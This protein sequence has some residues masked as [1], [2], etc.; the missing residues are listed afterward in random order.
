ML[1]HAAP[2]R[3]G[4]TGEHDA[5]QRD[6]AFSL[7]CTGLGLVAVA[8]GVT[9]WAGMGAWFVPKAIAVFGV[10]S[11]LVWRALP[12]HGPHR[13]FGAA[14]GITLLR[15]ALVA[16]LAAGVGEPA[17]QTPMLA[18]CLV[19]LAT[20]GA[21]LDAADG[22]IARR[23]GQASDFGARFDMETDALL[24]AVLSVLVLALD[25]TGA[26]VL[27]AGAMRYAFVLAA[28]AWPWLAAPLPPSARR[29]TVCVVQSVTLIVC[30]GPVVTPGWAGVIAGAGLAA[31]VYSFGVD[32]VGLAR[33]HRSAQKAAA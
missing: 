21:L 23:R 11:A 1:T 28:G 20:V 15:L 14:N 5:L 8:A 9:V 7:A 16:L 12:T 32:I 29:K 30:L 19:V 10:A 6:A 33:R 22:A 3:P 27:A 17:L 13:R 2:P 25:K 26:W 24:I 18:W 4:R 31:L